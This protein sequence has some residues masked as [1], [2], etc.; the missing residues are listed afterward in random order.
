MYVKQGTKI[1][2]SPNMAST[3]LNLTCSQNQIYDIKYQIS[4]HMHNNVYYHNRYLKTIKI[5][6][7]IY[8]RSTL[9]SDKQYNYPHVDTITEWYILVFELWKGACFQEI[10]TWYFESKGLALWVPICRLG[11]IVFLFFLL[12][13]HTCKI[14]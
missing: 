6:M 12:L 2:T 14:I 4:F 5:Y 10:Q 8:A 13:L 1:E 9:S 7:R 11:L 3:F